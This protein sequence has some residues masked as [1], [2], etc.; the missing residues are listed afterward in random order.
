MTIASI[1]STN[2]ANPGFEPQ[3]APQGPDVRDAT[4]AYIAPGAARPLTP[5]PSSLAVPQPWRVA[6]TGPTN[7]SAEASRVSPEMQ[8]LVTNYL[9]DLGLEAEPLPDIPTI[10]DAVQKRSA[11]NANLSLR[12]ALMALDHLLMGPSFKADRDLFVRITL[13]YAL[14]QEEPP[15]DIDDPVI[16]VRPLLPQSI[17]SNLDDIDSIRLNLRIH[18]YWLRVELGNARQLVISSTLEERRQV[19]R[20]EP[21]ESNA[22]RQRLEQKSIPAPSL[23]PI[24]RNG[25]ERSRAVFCYYAELLRG[26]GEMSDIVFPMTYQVLQAAIRDD[27]IPFE[28]TDVHSIM[29][30]LIQSERAL[31]VLLATSSPEIRL[32]AMLEIYDYCLDE[33]LRSYGWLRDSMSSSASSE[34][35]SFFRLISNIAVKA[36]LDTLARDRLSSTLGECAKAEQDQREA[37][38]KEREIWREPA[39]K[40]MR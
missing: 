3:I 15:M 9:R 32:N 20:L 25:A 40:A 34:R 1:P 36:S 26:P 2:R 28:V 23:I 5:S 22:Y 24:G 29:R 18:A 13:A 11:P 7:A 35:L 8:A 6:Q 14:R 38:K 30:L 39:R 19:L 21:E 4:D 33:S 17:V 37:A 31:T 16:I 10:L 27:T 12:T